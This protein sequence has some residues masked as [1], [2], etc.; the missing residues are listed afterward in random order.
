[1]IIFSKKASSPIGE[2]KTL[3][4]EGNTQEK[5]RA[6][7]QVIMIASSQASSIN[8]LIM[9]IIKAILP[10]KDKTLKKLLH[11]LWPFTDPFNRDGSMKPHMVLVCSHILEDLQSPNEYMRAYC[12]RALVNIPVKGILENVVPQAV[13]PLLKDETP[14]VRASAIIA[15]HATFKRFPDLLPDSCESVYELLKTEEYG[16]VVQRAISFLLDCS[17]E[18]AKMAYE[19]IFLTKGPTKDHAVLLSGLRLVCALF[20]MDLIQDRIPALEYLLNAASLILEG[21]DGVL[22]AEVAQS[23]LL[24]GSESHTA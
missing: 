18:H 16:E 5:I 24:I 23:L 3:I 20:S 9:P 2:L 13:P 6:M 14:I 22:L 10:S 7:K 1:M 21:G 17:P 15:T 11:L 12:L 19:T 8:P 4:E